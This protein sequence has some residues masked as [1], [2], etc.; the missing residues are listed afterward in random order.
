[1]AWAP[2]LS[3]LPPHVRFLAYNQRSYEGSSEAVGVQKEGG[4]D[5]T[6]AYLQDLL[7]VVD[8]A[9]EQLGVPGIG[10]DGKG[11]VA[12]LVRLTASAGGC[13]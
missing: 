10:A 5:A 6:A 9:V 7:G 12:L 2:V 3:H 8:F 1:M 11:G 13:F 4:T